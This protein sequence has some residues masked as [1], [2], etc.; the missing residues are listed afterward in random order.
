MDLNRSE[1]PYHSGRGFRG[2]ISDKEALDS[3]RGAHRFMP[4]SDVVAMVVRSRS[5]YEVRCSEDQERIEVLRPLTA[6]I[7]RVRQIEIA[8]GCATSLASG[9]QWLAKKRAAPVLAF[10]R[11]G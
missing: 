9:T 8:T 7:C 4:W 2:M 11:S 1:A 5:H 6:D 10:D 3:D